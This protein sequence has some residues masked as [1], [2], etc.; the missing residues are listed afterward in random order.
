MTQ[1]KFQQSRQPINPLSI[2]PNDDPEVIMKKVTEMEKNIP[3]TNITMPG[4]APFSVQGNIP[5]EVVSLFK[6]QTPQQPTEKPKPTPN[7]PRLAELLEE[8]KQITGKYDEIQLPSLGKFYAN[9]EAPENGKIHVRPMKGEEEEILGTTRFLKK[10]VAIQKVFDNCVQERINPGKWLLIDQTYLLIYLR[11]ISHGVSYDVEIRCPNCSHRMEATVH[12]EQLLVTKCPNDFGPEN[13]QGELPITKYKF[14]FHLPTIEDETRIDTYREQKKS[15]SE[16]TTDDI[17]HWRTAL[18][19]DDIAGLVHHDAIMILLRNLPLA[20][21]TYLKN[22][23]N[24]IPFG[25]DTMIGQW[26][27]A[28]NEDFKVELPFGVNFFYPKPRKVN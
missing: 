24:E 3:E 27:T 7:N 8:L 19:L 22:V 2:N 15:V 21:I 13:L 20:D 12:L 17:S 4:N 11:G 28:C 9:G 10:G 14:K 25:V 18:L 1:E 6:N 26:C 16:D 23:M 5:P